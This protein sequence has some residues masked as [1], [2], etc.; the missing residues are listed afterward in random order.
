[1]RRWIETGLVG[2][3]AVSRVFAQA[4]RAPQTPPV[5]GVIESFD[6]TKLV[7]K[8]AD[9]TQ[10]P[11]AV[12]AGVTVTF[13]AKR[14][15][16]DIKPGDFV[17]SG[18]TRGPDGT[19][20]ANE[21]R[22]FSGARGE[23]QFPMAGPNQVMTNATVTAVAT[24]QVMTN[25]TVQH[26]GSAGGTPVIRLSYHGAGAPGSPALHGACFRCSWWCWNRLRW[27]DRV[28]RACECAGGGAVA[29]YRGDAEAR[30]EGN[31][32]RDGER[33]G[34]CYG[35]ADH[36]DGVGSGLICLGAAPAGRY[37]RLI[38]TNLSLS[39][40]L[41][42]LCFS[43]G[44]SLAVS[45]VAQAP[46]ATEYSFSFP[47]VVHHVVQVEATFHNV[48]KM[49]FRVQMS[50]SSPGRYAAFEFAS[51][52]FEERFT[53][54]SGRLLAVTKP[55]PRSWSVTSRDGTVHV[56]YKLFG[57]RVDGTFMAIDVTPCAPEL[58]CDGDVG[59]RV[60][61]SPSE[62][63]VCAAR[64]AELV[65]C[66]AVISDERSYDVY[67]AEPAVLDGQPG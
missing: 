1:M 27:R 13:N 35:T 29:G 40:F 30:S 41:R 63:D 46:S 4:P 16:A 61:C 52:V 25:A 22:I 21:I 26:V 39:S 53:D 23:G 65:D 28:H 50:R 43:A 55:D 15:L 48:P 38:V 33:R 56:S 67:C 9:G 64:G 12:P 17:A 58:A 34:R 11:V 32:Q 7:L 66:D 60:R 44:V 62:V 57:D 5:V 36:G 42:A 31:R 24:Q 20:T 54:G 3:L 49:P 6:G 37:D 19:I 18:G 8:L 2:L 10:A 14:T 51:N 59:G 45:A 47:D